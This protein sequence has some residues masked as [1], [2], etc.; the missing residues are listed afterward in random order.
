MVVRKIS[1]AVSLVL[2][3]SVLFSLVFS[4]SARARTTEYMGYSTTTTKTNTSSTPDTIGVEFNNY[5]FDVPGYWGEP[6]AYGNEMYFLN[7]SFEIPIMYIAYAPKAYYTEKYNDSTLKFK[8]YF[9]ILEE[10][11]DDFI[12]YVFDSCDFEDSNNT[13]IAQ[14]PAI[15]RQGTCRIDGKDNAFVA[16]FIDDDYIYVI[17][18]VDYE[19]SDSTIFEDIDDFLDSFKVID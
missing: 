2:F 19:D 16:Q 7:D 12:G 14:K 1:K 11:M 6:Y 5:S 13:F 9:N 4:S 3:T 8:D 17:M 15:S 10:S 18:I